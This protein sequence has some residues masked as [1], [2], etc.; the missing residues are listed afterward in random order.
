MFSDIFRHN[1]HHIDISEDIFTPW[2]R[3]VQMFTKCLNTCLHPVWNMFIQI[4]ADTSISCLR[5]FLHTMF[6]NMFVQFLKTFLHDVGK[7]V[8]TMNED[9]VINLF[10]HVW[11]CMVTQYVILFLQFIWIQISKRFK[12]KPFDMTLD[13]L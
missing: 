9:I 13:G 5:E 7:Y 3:N 1:L 10:K 11:R 2:C 8:Y 12:M 4:F 6:E